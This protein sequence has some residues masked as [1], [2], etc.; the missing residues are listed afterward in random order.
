[1]EPTLATNNIAGF[2]AKLDTNKSGSASIMYVTYIGSSSQA[3]PTALT[4]DSSGNAYVGGIADNTYPHSHSFGSGPAYFV[5]KFNPTASARVFSTLL[6]GV[7]GLASGIALDPSRNVYVAGSTDSPGFPTT[8]GTFKTSLTGPNCAGP[9][10]AACPDGFVTKFN[11]TGS[12]LIYSTLLGGAAP[13]TTNGLR[14]NSAGMAFVTGATASQDFPV[15]ANGF[16]TPAP[17]GG[18][19]AFITALQPN[20]QSLYYSAVLGGNSAQNP[21]FGNA[22]FV[23]P[24]WNAWIGGTTGAADF[25]VTP[26]AFQPGRKG[27]SDGFF[28]KVVIAGDLQTTMTANAPAVTRNSTVTFFARVTNLGPDGSDNVV[29]RDPIPSGYSFVK[30]F[31]NSVT[32]CSTPAVGSTTGTITCKR[33]RLEKGQTVF[34]NVYL[35]AIGAAGSS[36]ANKITASAQTQDLKQGNNSASVSVAVK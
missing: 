28:A 7:D 23:D 20:G 4:V 2:L 26:N 19:D 13:E 21:S 22:I 29:L 33:T 30:V 16:G 34:L 1:M 18:N 32:S 11:A 35:K 9:G 25:P 36:H 3:R 24:A 6:L 17:V 14:V 31:S 8:P 15:T 27:A 10:T 12:A 5:T